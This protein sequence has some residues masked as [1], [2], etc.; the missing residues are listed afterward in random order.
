[1]VDF[2]LL[3]LAQRLT[4]DRSH[5]RTVANVASFGAVDAGAPLSDARPDVL[6]TDS[7]DRPDRREPLSTDLRADL[8]V[9]GGGYT[10]LWAAWL[11]R[12]Q[13]PDLDVVLIERGHVGCAASGRNGGFLSSS[14]T[15][16]LENGAARF[17]A[18]NAELVRVGDD[19]FADYLDDARLLPVDPHIDVTGG[20]SVANRRWQVARLRKTYDLSRRHGVDVEWW[21]RDRTRNT[22]R[23][24]TYESAIHQEKGEAL[25]DPARLAWGLAGACEMAGVRIFEGTTLLGMERHGA[26]VAVRTDRGRLTCGSVV[27]GTGAFDSPIRGI[28]RRVVPVYDYVLATEPLSADQWESIGWSG[29]QGISD[30]AN[31]FHYYRPTRD[32][33]ILWGGYDAVFHNWGRTDESLEQRDRTH[34]LLAAH[35]FETFPQLEGLRFSHRW[36]GVIDTSMRFSVGFGSALDGRVAYAIGYT[37]LGVGATRFGAQVCL[38]LLHKPDSLLLDLGLVGRQLLPFP[39]EPVRTLGIQLT[40]RAIARADDNGGRRGAWLGLLDR[41]GLGFDS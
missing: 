39:P 41:L 37:G 15:H 33:R 25:V 35:F 36:G 16:G 5:A 6:W 29:G 17:G 13:R 22:V 14:L 31:Q 23:S 12:R 30:Q 28:N 18:E 34:H 40:R 2:Q 8:V 38:D 19:N 1:M 26:G 9:V 27:L 7:P 3:G 21:D 20:L 32:R 10:G 4:D 11:A 24:P